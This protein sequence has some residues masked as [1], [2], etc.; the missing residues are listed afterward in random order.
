MLTLHRIRL[1]MKALERKLRLEM[2][3]VSASVIRAFLKKTKGSTCKMGRLVR[4]CSIVR[5][6]RRPRK[7]IGHGQIINM[8]LVLTDL[9]LD[10]IYDKILGLHLINVP[11]MKNGF[12]FCDV[13]HA[14]SFLKSNLISSVSF[15]II[16]YWWVHN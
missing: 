15:L 3:R 1:R 16:V 4:G 12:G 6:K 10:I 8:D 13:S 2:R 11:I 14:S 5:G 7:T 9:S